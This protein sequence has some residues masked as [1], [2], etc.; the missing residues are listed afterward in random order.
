MA[1]PEVQGGH[2][3][4]RDENAMPVESNLAESHG[5]AFDVAVRVARL[6]LESSGE[7]VE[8]MERYVARVARAY[9]VAVETVVLPESVI[10][11]DVSSGETDRV[12]VV[13][14]TPGIF[15]L[16]QLVGLKEVLGEVE[17]GLPAEAACSRL[18][19]VHAAPRL[20]PWWARVAGVALFAAGF[21]PSVVASWGEVGAAA[22]L[23]LLMGVLLIACE[24]RSVEPLLPFLAAFL[25]TLIGVTV[26]SGLS[27][28]NGITMLVLPA[29]FITV[30]GDTLSAAAAEL[31]G[32]RITT[33]AIRLVSAFFVLALIVVGIVGATQVTGHGDALFE[34]LPEPRLS[35]WV[36]MLAWVPFAVGLALAFNAPAELLVWLIPSVIGTFLL[37]QGATRVGGAVFG[38]L[39]A[40]VAL[41]AFAN[42]V[43]ARPRRPPRLV[44]LL[45]GFFVLTVGGVGVRGVTALVGGDVVS[46]VQD[47][48][49]F[50]LQVPTVAI[51]MGIGVALTN[52]SRR[53]G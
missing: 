42:L 33:G 39:V 34:T 38:T 46:G 23:G 21:A 30:P 50:G 44:L 17:L 8:T 26:L 49:Q 6:G 36:L 28:R 53:D 37:Q 15:R 20:W 29:L 51:A 40:G 43:G 5:S 31:L 11:T 32:G 12:S 16:D 41:G 2:D 22:I 19:A 45:G 24:G 47:V 14:A 9:G 48:V 25:L 7:G 4:I 13:R 3:V 35:F 18:D 1:A 10:I 27:A 52:R